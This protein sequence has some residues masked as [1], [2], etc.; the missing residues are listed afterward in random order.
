MNRRFLWVIIGI[1]VV[2]VLAFAGLAPPP[3]QK[4]KAS[5]FG[6]SFAPQ[7]SQPTGPPHTGP[8][9]PLAPANK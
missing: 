1:V 5:P 3:G 7:P 9:E 2:A 6:D 4:E 8:G